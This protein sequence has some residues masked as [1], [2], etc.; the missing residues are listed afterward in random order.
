MHRSILIKIKSGNTAFYLAV[1]Q[2][3]ERFHFPDHLDQLGQRRMVVL[4]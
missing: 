2:V 1:Q 3:D 4:L